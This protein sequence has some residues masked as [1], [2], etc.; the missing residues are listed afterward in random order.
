MSRRGYRAERIMP[1]P[2]LLPQSRTHRAL[3]SSLSV[4]ALAP[5]LHT[6]M[7]PF[8]R[9][10]GHFLGAF[11]ALCVDA[12]LAA[13]SAF[14]TVETNFEKRRKRKVGKERGDEKEEEGGETGGEGGGME[15]K[16]ER[17]RNVKG[18]PIGTNF[19]IGKFIIPEEKSL[20]IMTIDIELKKRINLEKRRESR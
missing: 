16:E 18:L 20:R 10:K 11:G 14:S 17:K 9:D 1:L 3:Q 19:L 12:L 15:D 13:F 7:I 2:V 8:E 4:L 5:F 6:S